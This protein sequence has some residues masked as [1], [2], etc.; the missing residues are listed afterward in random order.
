MAGSQRL[1]RQLL[2]FSQIWGDSL[3]NLT[4]METYWETWKPVEAANSGISGSFWFKETGKKKE[5]IE[6][7]VNSRKVGAGKRCQG[8]KEGWLGKWKDEEW[9][10]FGGQIPKVSWLQSYIPRVQVYI[11]RIRQRNR[12]WWGGRSGI[13]VCENSLLLLFKVGSASWILNWVPISH[14]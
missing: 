5:K 3:A 1:I 11:T 13:Q 10:R 6:P 8:S 14:L 12:K 9:N 7:A 2:L 4:A